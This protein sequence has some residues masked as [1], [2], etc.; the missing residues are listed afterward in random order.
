MPDT[1]ASRYRWIVLQTGQLPLR[2][3]GQVDRLAEHRC[4]ILM[5]WPEGE[6]PQA[7]NTVL[8]DPCFT[9]EGL[10]SAILELERL[11]VSLHVFNR[12]FV[13]HAHWDH[14]PSLPPHMPSIPFRMLDCDLNG[15]SAGLKAVH[16][17]GHHPMGM[18]LVF[19]AASGERV[20]VVG[21]AILDEEWLRAW[22]YFWPNAYVGPEVVDT[23][24]SVAA[25]IAGADIIVPG[26]GAPFVVTSEL[27]RSLLALFPG[28]PY[29][30]HC[31]EVAERLR[32]RLAQMG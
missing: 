15:V 12:V 30:A 2:P 3:D 4:T 32:E 5:L 27:V 26:H 8:T 23:W 13:T 19:C 11:G 25:I 14:M 10:R 29:A 7:G 6:T 9:L 24:R 22:N 21:D 20:W 1:A 31:L 18:A 17:P 28:A 16:C